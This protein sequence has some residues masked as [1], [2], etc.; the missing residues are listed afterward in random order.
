[1]SEL[2]A[3]ADEKQYHDFIKKICVDFQE[4]YRKIMNALGFRGIEEIEGFFGVTFSTE[5]EA[6]EGI[7]NL[8][9]FAIV[10]PEIQPEKYPCA[11]HSS[12]F[13]LI[14]HMGVVDSH[15][16]RCQHFVS[17]VYLS[18]FENNWCDKYIDALSS[19]F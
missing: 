13:D 12:A 11:I 9:S 4:D 19:D 8:E 6:D 15:S 1:M 14:T 17:F 7:V 10:D 3:F 2:Y 16:Y 5:Q 18:D